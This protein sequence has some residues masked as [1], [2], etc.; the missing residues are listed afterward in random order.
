MIS[1][2]VGL[3]YEEQLK[4][5]LARRRERISQGLGK[6]DDCEDEGGDDGQPTDAGTILVDLEK[7]LD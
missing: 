1:T 5:R 2:V 6:D 3:R 4:E 7:R